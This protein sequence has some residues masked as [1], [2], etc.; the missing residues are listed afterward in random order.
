MSIYGSRGIAA[1]ESSRIQFI[2]LQSMHNIVYVK[3]Y[4]INSVRFNKTIMITE[5]NSILGVQEL[6]VHSED[7]HINIRALDN[8]I[9]IMIGSSSKKCKKELEPRL[10]SVCE[11]T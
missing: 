2:E 7:R 4:I 6:S 3:T 8:N 10:K 1:K 11:I 5:L 9:C